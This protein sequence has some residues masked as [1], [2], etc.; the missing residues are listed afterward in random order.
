MATRSGPH[1]N[2]RSSAIFAANDTYYVCETIKLQHGANCLKLFVDVG[3]A[4]TTKLHFKAAISEDG[5]TSWY[6]LASKSGVKEWELAGAVGSWAIE[7]EGANFSPLQLVKVSFKAVSGEDSATVGIKALAFES[8]A[9][10]ELEGEAAVISG[11]VTVDGTVAVG[12]VV[13]IDGIVSLNGINEQDGYL[14]I[15]GDVSISEA[16]EDDEFSSL[17]NIRVR[18]QGQNSGM[19][20]TPVIVTF[21]TSTSAASAILSTG[22]YLIESDEDVYLQFAADPTA[23][24]VCFR[25]PLDTLVEIT[26]NDTDIKVAAL[27]VEY[28][29][30]VR[31]TPRNR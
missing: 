24:N 28:S 16:T 25:L 4:T 31:L 19:P 12:N 21:D 10:G 23:S 15:F 7:L 14:G 3:V 17:K 11:T 29:G 5:G 6:E 27:G 9:C 20:G 22:D 2:I 26:I 13:D 18:A 30:K 8:D 1:K